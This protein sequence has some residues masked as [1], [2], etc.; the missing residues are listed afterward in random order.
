L[1][2]FKLGELLKLVE[3]VPL[4]LKALKTCKPSK[5]LKRLKACTA[6]KD[7]QAF[8]TSKQAAFKASWKL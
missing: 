8:R 2:A 6:C 7:F 5:I 3:H 1:K 4:E